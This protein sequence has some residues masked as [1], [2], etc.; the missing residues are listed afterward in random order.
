MPALSKVIDDKK[1]MWDGNVYDSEE[2]AQKVAEGYA[3]DGFDTKI[4]S[5]EGHFL[6]YNRRE[7]K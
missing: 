5:E 2:E 1:Y 7:I 6:V 4:V 3:E